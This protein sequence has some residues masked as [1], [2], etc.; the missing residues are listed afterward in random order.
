MRQLR[1]SNKIYLDQIFPM[2]IEI[3]KKYRLDEKTR[4]EVT[5]RLSELKA[6]FMGD[7][8][9]ENYLFRGGDL[10]KRAAVLRL[11]KIGDRTILTYKERIGHDSGIKQ[12]IEHETEIADAAAMECIIESLG[13]TLNA[14][15][16]KRRQ[17]WIFLDVVITLD[18]LPFGL[19]MEIEGEV[20]AIEEAERMLEILD[21]KVEP[22][23]YP[24]L[25]IKYGTLAN[26]VC[27]AR[28]DQGGSL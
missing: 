21:L 9:E 14:V 3:E 4:A 25:A 18:E 27:E 24:R 6:E 7:A 10:K 28:F 5:A 12:R 15:Y 22:R 19:Y 23:G 8:F 17:T 11:R 1:L 13:Y 20:D 26:G 16:E 2:S